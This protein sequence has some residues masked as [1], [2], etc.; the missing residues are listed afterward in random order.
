MLDTISKVIYTGDKEPIRKELDWKWYMEG[1]HYIINELKKQEITHIYGI[2]RGGNCIAT[3][4]SYIM[5]IPMLTNIKKVKKIDADINLLIVDDIVD[6]GKTISKLLGKVDKYD[7]LIN[8]T[9]ACLVYKQHTSVYKPNISYL[10]VNEQIDN[11]L[12]NRTWYIFPWE[13]LSV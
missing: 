8:V 11:P 10:Q 1:V 9:T 13:R 5:N 6:S 3:S 4:I 7:N 12:Y 2:P